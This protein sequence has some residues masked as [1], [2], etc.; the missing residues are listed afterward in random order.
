MGVKEYIFIATMMSNIN[1]TIDQ[2]DNIPKELLNEIKTSKIVRKVNKY[3]SIEDYLYISLTTSSVI[4]KVKMLGDVPQQFVDIINNA[5]AAE[6]IEMHLYHNYKIQNKHR[7]RLPIQLTLKE[8][9]DIFNL[10]KGGYYSLTAHGIYRV[11]EL[12]ER[13]LDKK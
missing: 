10:V 12:L 4:R 13:I 1:K 8:R 5:L 6:A 2:N 9:T 11:K 3:L 7:I